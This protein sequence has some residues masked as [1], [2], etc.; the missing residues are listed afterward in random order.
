[1]TL[2]KAFSTRARLNGQRLKEWRN[3]KGPPTTTI[4][5]QWCGWSGWYQWWRLPYDHGVCKIKYAITAFRDFTL[6]LL[7]PW[8]AMGAKSQRGAKKKTHSPGKEYC[9]SASR[10]DKGSWLHSITKLNQIPLSLWK[11][12]WQHWQNLIWD[13]DDIDLGSFVKV[14]RTKDSRTWNLKGIWW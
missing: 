3:Q 9:Y 2:D 11:W 10:N 5:R 14:G 4:M 8:V 1:M 12:T 7:W 13:V 6:I